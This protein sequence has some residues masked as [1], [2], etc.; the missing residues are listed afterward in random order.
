M[1]L[2]FRNLHSFNVYLAYFHYFI[3]MY[4]KILPLRLFIFIVL[5]ADFHV[6]FYSLPEPFMFPIFTFHE[7][8]FRVNKFYYSITTLILFNNFV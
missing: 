5:F 1:Y 2:S 3:Q 8:K 7:I 4:F 6:L